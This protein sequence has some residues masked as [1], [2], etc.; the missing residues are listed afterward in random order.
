MAEF[1]LEESRHSGMVPVLPKPAAAAARMAED[2]NEQA[3][4]HAY[5]C[6]LD[7]YY[8]TLKGFFEKEP[9]EVLVMCSAI[10][11]RLTEIRALLQRAGSARANQLRTREVDP[12][13]HAVDTQFAIHSRRLS[14]LE[15]DY[16][17]TRGMT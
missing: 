12:L 10:T 14:G 13:I 2:G 17:M 4:L 9:D 11:A 1:Q 7:V 6:E 15:L 3:A 5:V 16:R 8:Q